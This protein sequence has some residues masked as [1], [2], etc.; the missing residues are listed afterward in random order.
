MS[1]KA[2]IL[3]TIEVRLFSLQEIR[4]PCSSILPLL[5]RRQGDSA[6]LGPWLASL[7]LGEECHRPPAAMGGQQDGDSMGSKT[8]IGGAVLGG[9]AFSLLCL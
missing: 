8:P 5:L 9:R 6:P 3:L 1:L 2:K 7:G 4:S